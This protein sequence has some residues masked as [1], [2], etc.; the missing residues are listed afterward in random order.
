MS[1]LRVITMGIVLKYQKIGLDS[2]LFMEI[3]NAG[4][5]RG[6]NWAE[7]SWILESNKLMVKAAEGMGT[8]IYKRYRVYDKKL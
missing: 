4:P 8:K 7:M 2:I 5:K 6:Y 1:G 3:Y